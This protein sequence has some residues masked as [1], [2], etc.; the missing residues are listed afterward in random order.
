[1]LQGGIFSIRRLLLSHKKII[2]SLLILDAVRWA[3][4]SY[5]TFDKDRV[6]LELSLDGSRY[7]RTICWVPLLHL[8]PGLDR[9]YERSFA[10]DHICYHLLCAVQTVTMTDLV[11]CVYLTCSSFT[12]S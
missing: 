5:L 10:K 2:T 4:F 11:S 1:M 7:D 9:P 12:I 6:D 8:S 3:L